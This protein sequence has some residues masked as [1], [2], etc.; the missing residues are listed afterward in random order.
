MQMNDNRKYFADGTS[1]FERTSA[2]G[3][4]P[5]VSSEVAHCRSG[6]LAKIVANCLNFYKPKKS[7]RRASEKGEYTNGNR[8]NGTTESSN[9]VESGR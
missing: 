8:N 3:A 6:V 1:V 4:S 2:P 9:P 7:R 5:A